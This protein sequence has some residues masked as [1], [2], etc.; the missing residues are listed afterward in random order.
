MYNILSIEVSLENLEQECKCHDF[1][2]QYS[3][4]HR[5]WSKGHDRYQIINVL[6]DKLSHSREA[7]EIYNKYAPDDYK[8]PLES[9][10]YFKRDKE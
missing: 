5:V 10:Y 8:L 6:L 4:D 1:F 9:K 7:V 3:D 2:Y